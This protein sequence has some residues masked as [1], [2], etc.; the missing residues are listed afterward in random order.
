M[1]DIDEGYI[2]QLA[3]E[4]PMQGDE[5]K[6]RERLILEMKRRGKN[7]K[8]INELENENEALKAEVERLRERCKKVDCPCDQF[9]DPPCGWCVELNVK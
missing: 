7:L 5:E 9:G 6:L 3:D 8:R 1:T 2:E 4:N